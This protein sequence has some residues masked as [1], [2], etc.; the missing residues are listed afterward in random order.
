VVTSTVTPTPT[1]TSTPTPTPTP[2]VDPCIDCPEGYVWTYVGDGICTS[3]DVV[4]ATP[5]TSSYTAFERK[6]FEYSM[7][8]T[9]VYQSGWNIN[10]TGTSQVQLNT[11]N[12]W[13]NTTGTSPSNPGNGPL[14]RTGLWA[15]LDTADPIDYPLQTWLGFNACITGFTGGLYY[16]GIGADNEFRLEV[17]GVVVL[18]T[19]ANSGLNELAKFRTWHVYPVTLSAGDHIIGL[20]GYN[21]LGNQTNPAGF[22]CEI[23][24]NTLAELTGATSVNDLNIVFTSTD[25]IGDIIP[26]VKDVNGVY[27]A[28]GYTCP[29]GYEYAQCTGNC[30]KTIYCPDNTTPTPT[31]TVTPTPTETGT[32]TPT[33]TPTDTGTPTPTPTATSTPTPTPTATPVCEFGIEV[34]IIPATPTPTPTATPTPTPTETGTPTPTP[35]STPICE[36]D[37]DVVVVQPTST[38]TPTATPTSTPTPTPT[39]TATPTPTP[40]STIDCTFEASFTEYFESTPT[41][42]PTPTPTITPICCVSGVTLNVTDPGWIKFKLC[43]G[44]DEYRQYTTTGTKVITECIQQYSVAVGVP[45]ADLAAFTVSGGGTNCGGD[46]PP[47]IV[48]DENTKI[49]IFFD[50]SGSMND[51]LPPLQTMRNSTLKNCLL[52]FYNNNS[53]KYDSLVTI[54]SYPNE[55]TFFWLTTTSGTTTNVS[56]VINLVFTDENSPYGAGQEHTTQWNTRTSDYNTDMSLLRSVLNRTP[57]SEYYR[58]IIFRVQGYNVFSNFLTAV[59]NGTGSYSGTNGLSDKT[60]MVSFIPNVTAASTAQYYTNQ[61]ISA[62]NTLGY[63]LSPC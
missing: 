21:L 62:I 14:N 7:S 61:I 58:A 30:W 46:C 63:N 40:T 13:K 37:I 3:T 59:F 53:A 50:S 6:Y 52:P 60:N 44:T 4:S 22:G 41:P 12:L 17:D 55:R 18:D 38:P 8:G 31:P 43:D 15:N 2:T 26:V 48:I 11:A 33:P 10:G 16:V 51:T 20:Y 45:Y 19:F 35:T 29:T 9:T 25:F 56:K 24:D 36:F 32:P 57:N 49:N 42:T 23:Y 34:I 54:T 1:A 39:D 5:P 28:S 47:A 27:L